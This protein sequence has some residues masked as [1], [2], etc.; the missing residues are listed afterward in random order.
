MPYP[1]A[2][3]VLPAAAAGA[4]AQAAAA[5]GIKGIPSLPVTWLGVT[6]AAAIGGLTAGHLLEHRINA[7]HTRRAAI[8]VA[9][10][11]TAAAVV[12]GILT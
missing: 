11:A 1:L 5:L 12:R 7:T 3:A 2:A 9:A 8:A 10:L 6:V 4:F